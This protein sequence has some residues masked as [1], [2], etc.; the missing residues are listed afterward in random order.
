MIKEELSELEKSEL[1]ARKD[2]LITKVAEL[3]E[4]LG[5]S[6]KQTCLIV[7]IKD[8]IYSAIKNGKYIGDIPK[9][10]KDIDNYFKLKE[11]TIDT[12]F[13]E[14]SYAP[15]STSR[16]VYSVIQSCHIKGGFAIATGDPGVGKTKAVMKYA[17]EN[18]NAVVISA[19][20]C[21]KSAKAILKLLALELNIPL[22]QSIDDMWFSI[23]SKLH[24]GMVVV[25]DEAQLLT[26]QA[27][28]TL[29]SI[30]DYFDNK[31]QTLGVALI[32]NNGIRER[33]EGKTRESYRQVNNR[34]WQR[35]FIRT[36]DV[37]I[38]DMQLLFPFLS[39]D[40]PELKFLL[41]VAQSDVGIR[42][43]VRLYDNACNNE[44]NDLKGLA[45][46]AKAMNV[47]LKNVDLKTI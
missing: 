14:I 2:E 25:V 37:K 9:Y 22:S 24:D 5:K 1:L 12:N 11:K 42:G 35:L 44:R 45:A 33:I 43:A 6:T 4:K 34:V 38:E 20:A 26:Y 27:I 19:S 39:E 28:E 32:G 7:G 17:E 46:A 36:I 30:A 47:N 13:H 15:I 29:R 40:S 10:L 31:G 16:K 18:G 21:S 3:A 23:I 41:K 8:S